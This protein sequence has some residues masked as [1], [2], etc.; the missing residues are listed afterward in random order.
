[1]STWN[2]FALNTAFKCHLN[3]LN[4]DVDFAA[5]DQRCSNL[6]FKPSKGQATDRRIVECAAAGGRALCRDEDCAELKHSAATLKSWRALPW[7]FVRIC[8]RTSIDRHPCEY[9]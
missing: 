6:S 4:G 8:E 1:L 7:D 9:S 5:R 2:N 3:E